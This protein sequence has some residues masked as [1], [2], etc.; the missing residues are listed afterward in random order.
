MRTPTRLY[1]PEE[2]RAE[3][4]RSKRA[5]CGPGHPNRA[6]A[7]R[8]AGGTLQ[9][10]A[11]GKDGRFLQAASTAV[12]ERRESPHHVR[13]LDLALSRAAADPPPR[14]SGATGAAKVTDFD[15]MLEKHYGKYPRERPTTQLKAD[16]QDKMVE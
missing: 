9:R 10:C 6:R 13:W 11:H 5:W 16:V 14:H 4:R 15:A 7:A 8:R 3:L 1:I 2:I 12:A